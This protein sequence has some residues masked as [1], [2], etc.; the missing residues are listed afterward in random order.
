MYRK[1]LVPVDLAH[2]ESLEKALSA[3]ASLGAHFGASLHLVAVTGSGPSHIAKTPEEFEEK[4]EEFAALQ[5]R[6]RSIEMAPHAALSHDPEVDLAWAIRQM[7]DEIG[8]DL[9]VMATHVPGFAEWIF[10][11]HGGAVASHASQS[12][13]LVR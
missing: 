12:V 5:S 7:A 9:I 3:A 1:I 13:M 11:S 10:A 6:R 2:A 8:A 4:L